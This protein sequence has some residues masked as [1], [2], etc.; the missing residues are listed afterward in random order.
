MAPDQG[1]GYEQYCKPT[2]RHEFLRTMELIVPWLALCEVTRPYYPKAG[3]PLCQ[4]SC[5]L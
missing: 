4:A 3:R 2:R 1:S 5:R